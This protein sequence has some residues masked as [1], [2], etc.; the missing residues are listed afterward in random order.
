VRDERDR[1][2][3]RVTWRELPSGVQSQFEPRAILLRFLLASRGGIQNEYGVF[4]EYVKMTE[5][6]A[7]F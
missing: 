6:G 4:L 7:T 3:A 2:P 1:D 5:K